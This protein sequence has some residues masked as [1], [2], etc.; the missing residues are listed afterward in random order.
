[1]ST[2]A[3]GLALL[4]VFP[5]ATCVAVDPNPVAATLTTK[6]AHRCRL[7][8]RLQ[9]HCC[10]AKQ[11]A[12]SFPPAHFDLIVSNPP[13]VPSAELL[14]LDPEVRCFE[15]EKALDGGCDGLQVVREILLCAR[16]VGVQGARIFLEVHH[17]HPAVFE[18][19]NVAHSLAPEDMYV[20]GTY[21]DIFGKPR[22]VELQLDQLHT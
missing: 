2:G 17:T 8:A 11:L 16:Q 14:G 5:N 22:F 1:M 3:I 20:I 6:N 19:P 12:E 7:E 10:S 13:Y 18:I 15:D 4:Q 21:R 9:V